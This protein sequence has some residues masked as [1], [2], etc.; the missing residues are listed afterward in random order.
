MSTQTLVT[1]PSGTIDLVT[2]QDTVQFLQ[3]NCSCQDALPYCQAMCCKQRRQYSVALSKPEA[4]RLASITT[5]NGLK[6]LAPKPG[7]S[8][9]CYYLENNR[10]L[11][12]QDKPENCKNWHCS[13]GGVGEGITVR[14]KGWILLPMQKS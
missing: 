13:P 7:N 3:Y 14:A 9:Q 11:I 12:H 1:V 4:E 6:I 8:N 10:C 5:D 2:V